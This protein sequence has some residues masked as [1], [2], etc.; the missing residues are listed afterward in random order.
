MARKQFAR[1]VDKGSRGQRIKL[2]R[3]NKTQAV[4]ISKEDLSRLEECERTPP[5]AVRSA[6]RRR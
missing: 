2:T 4:I 5:H 1:I 6:S 3:Y